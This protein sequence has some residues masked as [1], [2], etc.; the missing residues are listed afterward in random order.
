M[1]DI[2]LPRE[3]EVEELGSGCAYLIEGTG[4]RVA[5][6]APRRAVSPYCP[7]HHSLCYLACGSSAEA[8]RIREVETLASAV[9]GRRGRQ[10]AAP[11]EHFLERLE[12]AIRDF[13]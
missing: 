11:S 5:C 1:R 8:R 6:G 12:Q 4:G 13:S 10:G 7:H 9:G 3:F 2:I